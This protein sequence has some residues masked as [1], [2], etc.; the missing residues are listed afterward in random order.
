MSSAEEYALYEEYKEKEEEYDKLAADIQS[1]ISEIEQYTYAF[2]DLKS[3]FGIMNNST[4]KDMSYGAMVDDYTTA[5]EEYISSY[6]TLIDTME[7]AIVCLS[8][9]VEEASKQKA[10]YEQQK[11][12]AYDRYE[13]AK[14]EEEEAEEEERRLAALKALK[15]L[16]VMLEYIIK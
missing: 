8:G 4:G 14:R 1:K 12:A 13:D 10:F 11:N 15:N 16:R 5:M 3:V 2:S 6:E 7:Q 9:K